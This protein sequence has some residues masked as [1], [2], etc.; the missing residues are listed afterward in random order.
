MA[1]V[2]NKTNLNNLNGNLNYFLIKIK[3]KKV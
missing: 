2:Y 1:L 3:E